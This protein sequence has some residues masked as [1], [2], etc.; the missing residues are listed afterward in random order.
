MR[1]MNYYLKVIFIVFIFLTFAGCPS[2][3]IS[4]SNIKSPVISETNFTSQYE[5]AVN[6]FN[7]KNFEEAIKIFAELYILRDKYPLLS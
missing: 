7:K 5:Y 3:S 2:K 4:Y 1:K 6:L